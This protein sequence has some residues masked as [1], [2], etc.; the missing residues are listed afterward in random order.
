MG[1]GGQDG[2]VKRHKSYVIG[3]AVGGGGLGFGRR[4]AGKQ[5]HSQKNQQKEGFKNM[6]HIILIENLSLWLE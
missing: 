4:G 2:A 1:A 3:T 6:V 5:P